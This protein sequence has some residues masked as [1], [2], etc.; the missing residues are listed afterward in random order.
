MISLFDYQE[1]LRVF[2]FMDD[3]DF[4]TERPHPETIG[5]STLS[6][7]N[8]EEAYRRFTRV[9]TFSQKV[10]RISSGL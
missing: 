6:K 9:D 4:T 10:T 2:N 7:E 5:L 3:G 8:I 1:L